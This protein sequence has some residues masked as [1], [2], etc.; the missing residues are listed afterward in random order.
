[1]DDYFHFLKS[2]G[3]SEHA[4]PDARYRADALILPRLRSDLM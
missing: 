4:I 3:R 2:G 1:V